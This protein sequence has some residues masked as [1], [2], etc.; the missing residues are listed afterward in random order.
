MTTT[1]QRFGL[2]AV[3]PGTY[4]RVGEPDGWVDTFRLGALEVGPGAYVTASYGEG[5][6]GE[7]CA[8]A[9]LGQADDGSLTVRDLGVLELPAGAVEWHDPGPFD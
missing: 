6:T 4:E 1:D 5:R 8:V 3:A 2:G 7:R 9:L